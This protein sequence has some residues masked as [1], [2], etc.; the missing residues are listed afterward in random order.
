MGKGSPKRIRQPLE[1]LEGSEK[2]PPLDQKREEAEELG[3][4]WPPHYKS[5]I[6]VSKTFISP[7]VRKSWRSQIAAK[8]KVSLK[9]ST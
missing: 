5:P 4:S 7:S 3:D 9:S 1:P 8:V 2:A 6:L